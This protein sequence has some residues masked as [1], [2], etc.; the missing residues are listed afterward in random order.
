[1]ENG[2][3]DEAPPST[4]MNVSLLTEPACP[5][6]TAPGRALLRQRRDFGILF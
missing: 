6:T 2:G 3:G 5:F 1:M 4:T